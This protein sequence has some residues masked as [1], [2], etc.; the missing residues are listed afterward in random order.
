MLYKLS[1]LRPGGATFL[2]QLTENGDF[3]RSRGRWLS[4]K[5]LEIYIQEAAVATYQSRLTPQCRADILELSGHFQ[6]IFKTTI[7]KLKIH[8]STILWSQMWY[9]KENW[10]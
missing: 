4:S 7:T 3:V 10:G 8:I 1:F 9:N 2:L 6:E 5:V